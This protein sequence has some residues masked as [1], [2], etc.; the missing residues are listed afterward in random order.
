VRYKK[1]G[2]WTLLPLPGIHQDNHLR[3]NLTQRPHTA[4]VKFNQYLK[5]SINADTPT[6]TEYQRRVK[7]QS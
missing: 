2:H 4:D 1:K 7:T 3:Y 6:D 5:Q